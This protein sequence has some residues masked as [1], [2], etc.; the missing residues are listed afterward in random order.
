MSM[1]KRTM[2]AVGRGAAWL[3]PA[4]RR[5]WL[6]AVWAEAYEVP[7]GLPRLAWRAGGVWV[8]AREALLPRRLI[9]AALFAAAAS[10][11]AWA[12]WPQPTMGHAAVGQFGVIATVLLLAGLPLLAR[13]FLGPVSASRAGRVLRVFCCVAILALVPARIIVEVFADFAPRRTAY[14]R[15]NNIFNFTGVRGASSG[16][17]P[18]Q[19]EIVVL[20]IIAG[21][22]AAFLWLTSWRSRLS[23]TTLTIGTTAGLLLG[24][25]MY[26]VAPLGL[27]QNA[28]DPWLPGSDVD[29]LVAFAWLLLLGG[30][31]A[32]AMLAAR[33]R[34]GADGSVPPADIRI[35]QGIAAGVLANL[36][37]ALF[38][39]ALGTST[40]A[41]TLTSGAL[42]QWFYHGQHL[43][44]LTLYHREQIASVSTEVYVVVCIAF[45]VIGLIMG[46]LGVAGVRPGEAPVEPVAAA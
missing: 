45:P 44:T 10:A 33:R 37:G 13:R 39:T 28:T 23:R 31:A 24:V 8:L 6:A 11:A 12:A 16:G 41:L 3:L 43:S 38:V 26:A 34:R 32:A 18:W 20:L 22:V 36:T 7:Q 21:Y 46:A 17:A 25:V 42:R 5:G 2:A 9:K 27:G 14:L 4:G 15:I 1:L 30:P 40:T 19:G 29:P 35:R